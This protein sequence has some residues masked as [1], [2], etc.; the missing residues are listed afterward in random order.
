[1]AQAPREGRAQAAVHPPTCRGTCLCGMRA[2]ATEG[3]RPCT[4]L[5][6]LTCVRRTLDD[7][8]R[9]GWR[10]RRVARSGLRDESCRC[11]FPWLA[12]GRDSI[13]F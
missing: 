9:S 6:F 10:S 13:L 8:R 1:M 5:S 7:E 12:F 2:L 4:C 3:R 11:P